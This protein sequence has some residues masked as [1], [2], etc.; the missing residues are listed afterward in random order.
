MVHV[1]EAQA[2]VM[3]LKLVLTATEQVHQVKAEEEEAACL[4]AG[5]AEAKAEPLLTL[6][7]DL[8][9]YEKPQSLRSLPTTVTCITFFFFFFLSM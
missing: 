2:G 6:E 9:A 7:V 3:G 4:K 8:S 1:Q 5:L